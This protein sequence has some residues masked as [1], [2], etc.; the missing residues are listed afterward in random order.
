MDKEWRFLEF[1]SNVLKLRV[2][3]VNGCVT[4][5]LERV[6]DECVDRAIDLVYYSPVYDDVPAIAKYPSVVVAETLLFEKKIADFDAQACPPP[7]HADARIE[8]YP[9]GPP[10]RDLYEL[11]FLAGEWSRFRVD[12][13]LSDAQ[14]EAMYTEWVRNSTQ[15]IVADEVFVAYIDNAAVGM[16]TVKQNSFGLATVGLLSVAPTA[17]RTGVGTA[18][19]QTAEVWAFRARC[20][21]VQV[22]TQGANSGARAFYEKHGFSTVSSTP[23]YHFWLDHNQ[24]VPQNV[25]YFTGNELHYLRDVLDRQRVESCGAKSSACQQ[26]LRDTLATELVLLTGSGTSALEQA[27]I[28]CDFS[29]GDEVIMPSYTFVSTASAFVLRGAVPV[30][31]DI[32]PDTLNIDETK[33][34]AAITS[35]TKALV[36]VHYAGVGCEMDQIVKIAKANNLILIEDAAHAI[37]SKYNGQHLGTFG[38]FGCFSFHYTKNIICGEGGALAVNNKAFVERSLVVWEKGTNRFEFLNKKVDKYQWVDLG[39]SFVP[40]EINAS[41]LLAQ[42]QQGCSINARRMR[43]CTAY[44]GLLAPLQEAG[45]LRL[46]PVD[47]FEHNGHIFWVL[48]PSE[49]ERNSLRCY[50]AEQ[51]IQGYSHYVPLHLSPA[52]LRYGRISGDLVHTIAAGSRLLRLPLWPHMTWVHVHRVVH[53]IHDFAGRVPPCPADVAAHFSPPT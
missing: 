22:A 2:A 33:V 43:V 49:A 31:V 41:F 6:L 14:Y 38:D 11:G 24:Q 36:V 52:G 28:L 53:A 29:A 13:S 27:A 30:F 23:F 44:H 18:L 40:S 1:D 32:R 19:M 16:L 9:K 10:A 34:Q 50:L 45:L 35:K 25:P 20:D 21:R 17:Q 15:R 37:L 39:S 48:M 46:M 4:Q 47:K 26:L 51:G 42:L 3:S 8:S 5:R 12:P 7:S